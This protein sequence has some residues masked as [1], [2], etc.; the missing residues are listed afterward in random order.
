MHAPAHV[1]C[2]LLQWRGTFSSHLCVHVSRNNPAVYLLKGLI[3]FSGSNTVAI[4]YYYSTDQKKETFLTGREKK[5]FCVS[6]RQIGEAFTE[7]SFSMKACKELNILWPWHAAISYTGIKRH[8][9]LAMFTYIYIYSCVEL[10]SPQRL[11][12]G[13]WVGADARLPLLRCNQVATESKCRMAWCD[14]RS[15]TESSA[16]WLQAYELLCE[17]AIARLSE[18]T[19]FNLTFYFA[20]LVYQCEEVWWVTIKH[21]LSLKAAGVVKL[22]QIQKPL[23]LKVKET[24]TI[25][26]EM[27]IQNTLGAHVSAQIHSSLPH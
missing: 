26:M 13:T 4:K 8:R 20:S 9:C 24:K 25:I 5:I 18:D 17:K 6:S 27:K 2:I 3:P 15:H 10:P 11:Q 21:R 22:L 23:Q 19:E 12:R 1:T 16:R 14:M 7:K